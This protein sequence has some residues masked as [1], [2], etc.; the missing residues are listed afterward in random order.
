MSPLTALKG[1]FEQVPG[2]HRPHPI[3]NGVIF[4]GLLVALLYCGFTRTVPFMPEDGRLVTAHFDRAANASTSNPVRVKGVDVGKIEKIERDPSGEGALITMRV[5]EDGF[6]LK[7]DARAA[8]YWRTL[9]GR[10]MY[11]ELD[12]GSSDAPPLGDAKIALERT[13]TQVEFDELLDSY[14]ED[15]REGVRTFFQEADEALEG[16]EAGRAI[17]ELG[18]GLTPVPAAMRAL[19]GTR[20][21][22]DL[23]ELVSSASKALDALGRDEAALAGLLDGAQ[24]TVGVLAARRADLGRILEDSPAAMRDTQA[25]TARLRRTLDV[26]DP[27]ASEL[28]PGVRR[29]DEA[30]PPAR[31]ALAQVSRLTPTALPTLRD[32]RPALASLRTAGEQGSPFVRD[33]GPTLVRLR[34]EILPFLDKRDGTTDLR[35]VEAI[36]PFF[37][38]LSD[39]SAQFDANGHMQRFQAGQG[40]RSLGALPCQTSFFDPEDDQLVRCQAALKAMQALARGGARDGGAASGAKL[41][42]KLKG[43]GR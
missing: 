26:L 30:A 38:V 21:G 36:G 27:V 20:P 5:E 42:D 37:S 2:Q 16:D 29:L 15:G 1:R 39:S 14:D 23:P 9:L 6:E 17:A 31:A 8:I 13:E 34:D 33:L 12:P 40:E 19:R 11:I 28:R 22:E 35:N 32:L 43:K 7:R 3:R 24:A 4:L 10:N 18:P 41:V 25:T